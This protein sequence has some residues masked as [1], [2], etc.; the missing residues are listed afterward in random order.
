MKSII[1][2]V[3]LFALIGASTPSFTHIAL[4]Q[5][6]TTATYLNTDSVPTCLPTDPD[7]CGLTPN[8]PPRTITVGGDGLR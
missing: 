5:N 7:P 8:N 3:V 4:S 6:Q 1:P 2:S